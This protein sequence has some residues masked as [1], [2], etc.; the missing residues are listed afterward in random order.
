MTIGHSQ[1]GKDTEKFDTNKKNF[2]LIADLFRK[3]CVLP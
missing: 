3:T 1:M 2:T